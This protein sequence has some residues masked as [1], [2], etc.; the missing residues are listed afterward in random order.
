LAQIQELGIQNIIINARKPPE[1]QNVQKQQQN[2]TLRYGLTFDDL[3]QIEETIPIMDSVL[4]VHDLESWIWFKSR[5]LEAKIR[6]VTP[7]YYERLRLHPMLGRSLTQLD[8]KKRLRVCMIRQGLL[9]EAKYLGDPLK[10]DLKIGRD[11]FRVVGVLPDVTF[12]TP[13]RA[14]LGIDD[15]TLEVYVPFETVVDRYGLT[16]YTTRSGSQE[17]TRVELHQ[18]VCHVENEGLVLQAARDLKAILEKFHD[19]KDYQ[20][21]VPLELLESRQRTQR[22]FNIVL[23]IIAGISLLVGGIGILNIM[24]ASVVER[25]R[26]IGIRR[27][28]GASAWDITWQFLIET[29][30]LST[31][32]GLLGVI[33]GIVGV[34]LLAS[35]TSWEPVITYWAVSVSLV[36]SCMTGIVFGLYPARRAALMDPINALRH[37]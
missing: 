29:V 17:S 23:P 27:A 20:V 24:L 30:T 7:E 3:E 31:V 35:F 37:D 28:V 8:G 16:S 26:E 11:Y 33:L 19:K 36:I 32:G 4:P 25:T 13:N 34:F 14:A 22:V 18:I 10:L 15:R 6:G 5:R 12:Q 9:K 21:I 2:W 1:E